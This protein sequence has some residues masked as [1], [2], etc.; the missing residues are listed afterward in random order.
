M[1][2]SRVLLIALSENFGW[3]ILFDCIAKLRHL[4]LTAM[5]QCLYPMDLRVQIYL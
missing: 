3:Q 5:Q 1:Y 2:E 4:A